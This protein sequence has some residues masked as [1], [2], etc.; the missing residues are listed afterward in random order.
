MNISEIFA[1]I[2]GEGPRS[3]K[4]ATFI[5]TH[6]CPLRCTYCDSL[7][8][9]EGSDFK[10]MS[11]DEI[12][13]EVNKIGITNV[14]LTG[15]EPL[16]QKDAYELVNRLAGKGYEVQIET[17]GAVDYS[18]YLQTP[19]F[20]RSNILVTAD[21]K[22]PSS[23][24]EDKMIPGLIEKLR[25]VDVLKFVVGSEEDLERM[26]ELSTKTNAQVYVSPVFG[27]VEPKRI[28][29]YMLEHKLQNVK[30]QLQAHK[31]VWEPDMRGV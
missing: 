12:L 20:L 2:D 24:M 6:A 11:V 4:L 23:G 10:V 27:K 28:V 17:S 16:I 7:Y 9:V 13:S 29:E 30:F 8:A 26:R 21:W 25:F 5:R 18:P 3:G 31:I 19:Y 15:G 1:S 14:T 22:C